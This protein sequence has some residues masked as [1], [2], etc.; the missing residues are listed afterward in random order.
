M[1]KANVKNTA[2]RVLYFLI[3]DVK[4]TKQITPDD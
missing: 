2:L 1:R 4:K 3:E